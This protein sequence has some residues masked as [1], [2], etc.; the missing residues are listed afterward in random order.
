MPAA[1]AGR[2][3]S[4]APPAGNGRAREF[5]QPPADDLGANE[6]WKG[7]LQQAYTKQLRVGTL[8]K[9]EIAYTVEPDGPG[10][11]ATVQ[12]PGLS[13]TFTGEVC[14]S[15][16]QAEHSAA[17]AAICSDFPGYAEPTPIP[18]PSRAP[19]SGKGPGPAAPEPMHPKSVLNGLLKLVVGKEIT[20]EDIEYQVEALEEGDQPPAWVCNVRL[21]SR[22]E[23]L[24]RV[25]C[26]SSYCT[27]G[28]KRNPQT[29]V[30]RTRTAKPV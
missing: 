19:P 1:W 29:H 4:P 3:L 21:A 10:F 14:T 25:F 23:S 7:R 24:D 17:M 11:I 15:K 5:S 6:N 8:Q 26:L 13:S 16:K 12:A 18:K 28:S 30:I 27:D 2:H 9:D 20:R 22:L